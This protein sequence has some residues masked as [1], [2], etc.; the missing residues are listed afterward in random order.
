LLV[1]YFS[2]DDQRF[3]DFARFV[4]LMG[5]KPA[6]GTPVRRDSHTAPTLHVVWVRSNAEYLERESS[7]FPTS[8][9]TGESIDT[10][11]SPAFVF[12]TRD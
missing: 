5:G 4:A 3:H 12:A 10:D 2:Q 1:H 7:A 6:K 8:A 9:R 11:A